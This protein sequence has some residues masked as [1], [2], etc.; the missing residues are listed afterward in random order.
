MS[1]N[2]ANVPFSISSPNLDVKINYQL[3]LS[4]KDAKKLSVSFKFNVVENKITTATIPTLADFIGEMDKFVL[5]RL[6]AML[7]KNVQLTSMTIKA[8]GMIFQIPLYLFG[9]SLNNSLPPDVALF[10]L[11]QPYNKNKGYRLYVKGCSSV[12]SQKPLTQELLSIIQEFESLF[13]NNLVYLNGLLIL[14][15]VRNTD[16]FISATFRDVKRFAPHK[17]SKLKK[18]GKKAGKKVRSK[19]KAKKSPPV[20]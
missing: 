18:A 2:F 15:I 6:A 19:P 14:Q 4:S 3:N 7:G 5:R 10:F 12:F 8:S 9:G 16:A 20:S 17:L 1:D 11:L 13:T